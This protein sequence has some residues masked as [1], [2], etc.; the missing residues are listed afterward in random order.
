MWPDAV[1]Y[2][3]MED[4]AMMDAEFFDKLFRM[5]SLGLG[6]GITLA[7]VAYSIGTA[8]GTITK[9]MKGGE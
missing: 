8:I 7:L 6:G 5:F 2:L 4:T 9:I 1:L 3:A